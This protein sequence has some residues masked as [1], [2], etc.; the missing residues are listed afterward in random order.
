MIIPLTAALRTLRSC[1]VEGN[2]KMAPGCLLVRAPWRVNFCK[3]PTT[4]HVR[5]PTLPKYRVCM[6]ECVCVSVRKRNKERRSEAVGPVPP[7]PPSRGGCQWFEESCSLPSPPLLSLSGVPMRASLA[8]F[9]SFGGIN[10][11]AAAQWLLVVPFAK[12][13]DWGKGCLI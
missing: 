2:G 4:V 3:R 12:Q 13:A 9:V 11:N 5:P 10:G 8:L 1:G 7:V 6:Y